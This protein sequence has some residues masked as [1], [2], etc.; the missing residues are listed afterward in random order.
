M[1]PPFKHC[2]IFFPLIFSSY[3]FFY[4]PLI[5]SS[6]CLFQGSLSI[7][8]CPNSISCS[9]SFPPEV[10]NLFLS[11]ELSSDFQEAIYFHASLPGLQSQRNQESVC[12][13]LTLMGN[14]FWIAE[15]GKA[16]KEE[17]GHIAEIS[18]H[19]LTNYTCRYSLSP[20]TLA[21]KQSGKIPS[22]SSKKKKRKNYWK[23]S[24]VHEG[25]PSSWYTQVGPATRSFC[26]E[27]PCCV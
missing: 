6:Y 16:G 3:C 4:F 11:Q 2:L 27:D 5:F 20:S 13:F 14:D 17:G 24:S 21:A 7:L 22:A 26:I 10:V 15:F 1:S 9:S 25:K 8:R 18:Q 23:A 12:Y 19:Y